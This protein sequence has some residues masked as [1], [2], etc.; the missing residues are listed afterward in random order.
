VKP[1]LA[2]I[3]AARFIASERIERAARGELPKVPQ[4]VAMVVLDVTHA[5]LSLYGDERPSRDLGVLR[6]EAQH[7]EPVPRVE[8]FPM[9]PSE[10]GPN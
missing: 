1:L 7:Y 9:A 4:L 10:H 3:N 5:Y 6:R 8:H 2:L